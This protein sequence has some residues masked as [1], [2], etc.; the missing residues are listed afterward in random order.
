M[1][2]SEKDVHVG[3]QKWKRWGYEKDDSYESPSKQQRKAMGDHWPKRGR[4]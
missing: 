2:K 1:D 4:H 3:H